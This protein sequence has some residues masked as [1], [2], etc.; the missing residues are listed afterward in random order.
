MG[1]VQLS[2]EEL[3]EIL[4]RAARRGARAA[5]QELGLHDESAPKDLEELRSLISSWR[6]TRK[7]IWSTMVKWATMATLGFISFAIWMAFK[8]EVNK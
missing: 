3:E 2:P 4:D 7:A 5:L 8:G 6:E 1:A